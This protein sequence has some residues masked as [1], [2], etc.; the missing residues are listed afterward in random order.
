MLLSPLLEQLIETLRCLPGV[1]PKSAQRMAFQLLNG[2][3][4]QGIKL[5]QALSEAMQNLGH[6]ESCRIYAEHPKCQICVSTHRD[7]SLLCIVE[8]PID[9][10]AVES[11]GHYR[12]H[13]YVLL[14]HLSPLDGIGPE[15]LGI[16]SLVT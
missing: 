4:Q 16:L 5:A 9:V 13:Y 7:Q 12:G 1:G 15:E 8:S 10:M 6:C 2:R 11:M 3:R 14:G